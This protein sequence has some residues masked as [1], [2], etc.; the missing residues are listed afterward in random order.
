MSR[1]FFARAHAAYGAAL[2]STDQQTFACMLAFLQAM[3]LQRMMLVVAAHHETQRV[4]ELFQGINRCAVAAHHMRH[5][6]P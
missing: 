5:S 1:C 6:S 4:L 2:N 3:E